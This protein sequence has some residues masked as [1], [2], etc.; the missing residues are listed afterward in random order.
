MIFY[1]GA[2]KNNLESISTIDFSNPEN[3]KLKIFLIDLNK[4][5]YDRKRD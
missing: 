2:V 4:V 1:S 5:R 3:E